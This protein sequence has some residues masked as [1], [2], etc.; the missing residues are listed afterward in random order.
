M[1][2]NEQILPTMRRTVPQI[3]MYDDT[4]FPGW[5][6]IGQTTRTDV[7]QRI[8]EQHPIT[9]PHKTYHLLWHAGAFYAA[10]GSPTERGCLTKENSLQT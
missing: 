9:E 10:V 8:D 3:Y 1:Q 4:S 7:R 2:T 5:I 6:K